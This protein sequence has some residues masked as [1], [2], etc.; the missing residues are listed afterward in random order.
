[1]SNDRF[2]FDKAENLIN[3]ITQKCRD[4]CIEKL[5]CS[6]TDKIIEE[7]NHLDP[8]FSIVINLAQE[9]NNSDFRLNI[10]YHQSSPLGKDLSKDIA[11][12]MSMKLNLPTAF[13]PGKIESQLGTILKKTNAPCVYIS[14][15]S[16]IIPSLTSENW[17]VIIDNFANCISSFSKKVKPRHL[18]KYGLVYIKNKKILL[19]QPFIYDDF[20]LPGG[21][22]EG[23]ETAIESLQ[24]EIFEE[25]GPE[26][27]LEE[28]TVKYFGN[29]K[30]IAA[31]KK[32]TIVEIEVYLG[33]VTGKLKASSEIKKLHWFSWEDNHHQLSAIIKNKI[34][35]ELKRKNL[36]S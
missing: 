15:L 24:R 33:E 10:Y 36:I 19:C 7:I 14:S 31:G 1:M 29:F 21:V 22:K 5:A 4:I 3:E 35:P 18:F 13:S 30:D 34:L 16:S 20:I 2:I 23:N 11:D 9:D 12:T 8:D 26:A 27:N 17:Q 28:H 6:S 32:R 25:L